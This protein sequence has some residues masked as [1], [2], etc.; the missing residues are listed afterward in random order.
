MKKLSWKTSALVFMAFTVQAAH[1]QTSSSEEVVI[2]EPA[3]KT[4]DKPLIK[5]G[6]ETRIPYSPIPIFKQ[7]LTNSFEQIDTGVS[8]GWITSDVAANLKQQ[9]NEI[10]PLIDKIKDAKGAD[11]PLVNE[12]EQKLTAWNAAIFAS[13]NKKETTPSAKVEVKAK[14]A[15]PAPKEKAKTTTKVT[16]KKQTKSIK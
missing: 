4:N 16:S 12:V 8:K 7:R 2:T 11:K 14:V 3:F 15:T 9:G 10:A 6:K 5:G 13:F 1:A